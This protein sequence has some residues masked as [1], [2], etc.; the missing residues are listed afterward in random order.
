MSKRLVLEIKFKT[1]KKQNKNMGVGGAVIGLIF[2][3]ILYFL[4]YSFLVNSS[5][6]TLDYSTWRNAFV[7]SYQ[8]LLEQD[9]TALILIF[10]LVLTCTF[11]GS[12]WMAF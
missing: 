9:P 2:G 7:S 4:I 5:N 8:A 3:V 10:I 12:Y 11:V 6:M 1:P